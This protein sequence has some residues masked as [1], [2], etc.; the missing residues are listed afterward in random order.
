MIWLSF[1]GEVSEP[2]IRKQAPRSRPVT[3]SV[4]CR[5]WPGMTESEEWTLARL[6]FR[7]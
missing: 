3:G 1:R 4:R 5:V 2:G 6:D 7:F